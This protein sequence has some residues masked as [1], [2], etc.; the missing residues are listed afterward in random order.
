MSR[1]KDPYNNFA[2]TITVD[3]SERQ[4]TFNS[5]GITGGIIVQIKAKQGEKL[6]DAITI[7]CEAKINGENIVLVKSSQNPKIFRLEF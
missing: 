3:G 2:A 5:R 7:E 6:V 1:R 4:L